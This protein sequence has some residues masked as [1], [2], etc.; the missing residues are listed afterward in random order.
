MSLENALHEWRQAEARLRYWQ[1]EDD[2]NLHPHGS[3]EREKLVE[4]REDAVN[5]FRK[6]VQ[7]A[8]RL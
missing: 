2:R 5:A 6:A 4:A 7:S 1:D 8:G 3:W